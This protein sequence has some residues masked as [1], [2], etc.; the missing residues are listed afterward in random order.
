MAGS[1]F[2]ASEFDEISG[3]SLAPIYAH[4]NPSNMGIDTNQAS[5]IQ[6]IIIEHYQDLVSQVTSEQKK[7]QSV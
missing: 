4:M 7:L 1:D 5:R 6:G 3:G 2:T